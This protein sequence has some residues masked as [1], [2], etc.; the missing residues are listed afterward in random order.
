MS[1]SGSSFLATAIDARPRDIGGFTV[2]RLLPWRETPLGRSLRLLRR[3]G[4]RA[5]P[6]RGRARRPASPPHRS[7]D[8]DLPVRGRDPASRQ[9]RFSAGD[10]ARRRQLDDRRPGHRALGTDAARVAAGARPAPRAAALVGASGSARGHGAGVLPP[11][12]EPPARSGAGRK[13]PARPRRLGLRRHVARADALVAVLRRR[14]DARRRRAAPPR[15]ARGAG[16]LRARPGRFPAAR[17]APAPGACSC[18]R[19]APRRSFGPS[20]RCAPCSSAERRST[21]RDTSTGT[22]CR[23]RASGSSRRSA[24]GRKDASRRSPET[25]RTSSRCRSDTPGAFARPRPF[26][27]FAWCR[28][29]AAPCGSRHWAMRSPPGISIGPL[30]TLPPSAATA[31]T[32]ASRSGTFA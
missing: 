27:A 20:P 17:S 18:S 29:N 2:R 22:S 25:K 14:R 8:G 31:F 26:Q 3:D 1:D 21:A 28:A 11:P 32:A 13:P 6:R 16:A 15:R 12:R 10:P 30:R 24:T 7:R 4:A 9:P 19:R 23:A 5:V